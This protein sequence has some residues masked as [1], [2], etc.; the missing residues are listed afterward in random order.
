MASLR[1]GHHGSEAI[2]HSKILESHALP[3]Q[4]IIGSDSHTPHAGAVGCVAFGVGTTAIFNSWITKDVRLTVPETVKVVVKGAIAGERHRQG[5][6][7]R[8]PAPPLHQEWAGHREAGGVMR[9]RGRGAL[10]GRARDHDQHDGRC[11]R[12]HGLR[13]SRREDGRV[14]DGLP[15]DVPGRRREGLRGPRVRCA[16]GVLRSDRD[17]CVAAQADGRAPGR[18]GER[19]LHRGAWA[20]R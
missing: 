6:H 7:A 15:E 1:L 19:G 10:G 20:R 8:D 9:R 12:L 16:G 14:P 3:G 17:R 13:G 18:S 11:G 5:L 2:C 4:V